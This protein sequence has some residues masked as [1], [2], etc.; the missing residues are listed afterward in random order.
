MIIKTVVKILHLKNL[1]PA[2]LELDGRIAIVV[3]GPL[4]ENAFTHQNE[5]MS[6]IASILTPTKRIQDDRSVQGVGV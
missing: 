6:I 1:M 2:S 4:C 5:G 3:S